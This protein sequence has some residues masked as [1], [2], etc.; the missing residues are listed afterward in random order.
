[1]HF[2]YAVKCITLHSAVL[3]ICMFVHDDVVCQLK[4]KDKIIDQSFHI[5]VNCLLQV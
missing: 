3:C 2:D 1:M 4:L 5:A